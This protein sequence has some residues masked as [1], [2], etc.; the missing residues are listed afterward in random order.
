MLRALRER[1]KAPP[2][3]AV[4]CVAPVRGLFRRHAWSFRF[5]PPFVPTRH[6]ALKVGPR[7]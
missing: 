7:L 3:S 1:V 2:P 6:G 4:R 5:S